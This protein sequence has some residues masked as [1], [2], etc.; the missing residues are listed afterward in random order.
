MRILRQM[1]SHFR[2]LFGE[3]AFYRGTRWPRAVETDALDAA[4]RV[5]DDGPPPPRMTLPVGSIPMDDG[6][7]V[8]D[9][10]AFAAAAT[11]PHPARRS[12]RHKRWVGSSPGA[13]P[14]GAMTTASS[15]Q[16]SRP[17]SRVLTVELPPI[18]RATIGANS[19][20]GSRSVPPVV[21]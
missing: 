10:N 17:K 8:E 20:A 14:A 1:P 15:L 19:N 21:A 2:Q 7:R 6:P 16:L 13:A 18:K 4:N 12:A 9:A 5:D 11:K 3:S